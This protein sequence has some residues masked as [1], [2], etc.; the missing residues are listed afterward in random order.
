V[1]VRLLHT[2]PVLLAIELT[3]QDKQSNDFISVQCHALHW[4]D[5]KKLSYCKRCRNSHSSHP[6]LCQ[7]TPNIWL[8]I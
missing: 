7:S 4:T 8:P 3:L 2:L 6:L 5:N 1:H